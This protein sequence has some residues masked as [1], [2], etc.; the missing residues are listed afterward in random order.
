MKKLC[1]DCQY[2]IESGFEFGGHRCMKAQEE[3]PIMSEPEMVFDLV[4]G[5]MKEVRRIIKGDETHWRLYCELQRKNSW[6]LALMVN[7]CGK[8]GRWWVKK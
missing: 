3:F 4:T 5:K 7:T 1:V 8:R 2:H 6:Y